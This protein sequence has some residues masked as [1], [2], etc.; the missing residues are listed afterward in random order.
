MCSIDSKYD[1]LDKSFHDQKESNIKESNINPH[2]IIQFIFS[3]KKCS[4]LCVTMK[5]L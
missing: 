3:I 2:T 5:C 1:H 4:E